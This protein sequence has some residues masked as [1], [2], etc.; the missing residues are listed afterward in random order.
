MTG[1]EVEGEA[2]PPDRRIGLEDVGI[3]LAEQLDIAEWQAIPTAGQVIVVQHQRL[4]VDAVVAPE[5][6]DRQHGAAIVVHEV[7][8]DLVGSV[9]Q[10]LAV[11]GAQQDGRRIDRARRQDHQLRRQL[12]LLAPVG[13]VDRLD[14]AARPRLQRV[15]MG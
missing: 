4:L 11:A 8:A 10:P 5:R 3:D 15:D 2:W 7:A 14:P 9:C 12:L 1:H 13:I 6:I